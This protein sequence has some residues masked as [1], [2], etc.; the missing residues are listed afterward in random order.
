MED[1]TSQI[2]RRNSLCML[3]FVLRHSADQ[4]AQPSTRLLD[5]LNHIIRMQIKL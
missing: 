1:E 3:E 2:G 4:L 5:K